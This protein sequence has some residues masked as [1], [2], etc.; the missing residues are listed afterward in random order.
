MIITKINIL[1]TILAAAFCLAGSMATATPITFG[2]FT[3]TFPYTENGFTVM[4]T[5]TPSTGGWGGAYLGGIATWSGGVIGFNSPGHPE[6]GSAAGA[7]E[8]TCINNGLFFFNSVDLYGGGEELCNYT[9]AG[10][11]NG[12]TIFSSGGG[13]WD[14]LLTINGNPSL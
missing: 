5:Q 10:L 6:Y 8:V 4:P 1:G 2:S 12:S 3:G 11:L 9:I 14:T 7:I 13:D